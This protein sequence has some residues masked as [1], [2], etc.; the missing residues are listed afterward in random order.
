MLSLLYVQKRSIEECLYNDISFPFAWSPASNIPIGLGLPNR[1]KD[2]A[3][4]I[5]AL[6]QVLVRCPVYASMLEHHSIAHNGKACFPCDL[7]YAARQ[8]RLGQAM[9]CERMVLRVRAGEFGD[10]FRKRPDPKARNGVVFPQCDAAEL[11]FDA[12]FEAR[13]LSFL[14]ALSSW[15]RDRSQDLLNYRTQKRIRL[16]C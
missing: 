12:M 9:A 5:N 6:L 15:E 16:L 11:L 2:N 8:A 7:G 13:Q 10:A 4:F 14:G 3:C 1:A